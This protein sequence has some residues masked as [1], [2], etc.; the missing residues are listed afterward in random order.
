M[1]AIV[2]INIRSKA[3][4]NYVDHSGYRIVDID[5]DAFGKLERD[6]YTSYTLERLAIEEVLK[7]IAY[8]KWVALYGDIID[9]ELGAVMVNLEQYDAIDVDVCLVMTDDE[10]RQFYLGS[11]EKRERKAAADLAEIS[12]EEGK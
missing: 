12:I 6:V 1:K 5:A 7:D 9:L 3:D 2:N 11:L 10:F 4:R 8:K